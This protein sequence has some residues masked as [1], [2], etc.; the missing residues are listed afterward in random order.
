MYGSVAR[1]DPTFITKPVEMRMGAQVESLNFIVDPG[2]ER[3]LVL[4]LSWLLKW[5]FYVN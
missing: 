2:M 5:N 3:P 4:G 1:E